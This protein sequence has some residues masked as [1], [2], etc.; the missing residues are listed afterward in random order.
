MKLRL[1]L[2]RGIPFGGNY[3][4]QTRGLT[5][6]GWYGRGEYWSTLRSVAKH[7]AHGNDEHIIASDVE[8]DNPLVLTY[9]EADA[10]ARR[11]RTKDM[12]LS[13]WE[14]HDNAAALSQFFTSKG[15]DS[16]IIDDGSQV[17]LFD[18]ENARKFKK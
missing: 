11:F 6:A 5:D 12:T 15:Y 8:L 3:S 2:Y 4:G 14:R 13:S 17:L 10:H 9:D 18:P 16:L 1:T 7:Y